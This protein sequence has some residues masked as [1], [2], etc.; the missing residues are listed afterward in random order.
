MELSKEHKL[1]LL[2]ARF[3][4]DE[5]TSE[6]VKET[7]ENDLIDTEFFFQI[8]IEQKVSMIVFHRLQAI[9]AIFEGEEYIK[10]KRKCLAQLRNNLLNTKELLR[11]SVLAKDYKL[12]IIPY[13]GA[14][15][16]NEV[17]GGLNL[18]A[19]GDIDFWYSFE[20][21]STLKKLMEDEGYKLIIDYNKIQ[22][23]FFTKINC[24]Y[25]FYKKF[26][27]QRVLIE[28]HHSL[29][30]HF[31]EKKP[32]REDLQ[33]YTKEQILLNNKIKVFSPEL[34]LV[35]L[36]LHHGINENWAFFKHY[37]DLAAFINRYFDEIN[38]KEVLEVCGKYEIKKTFL[39]GV[40]ITQ[41]LLKIDLPT[42]LKN[43]ASQQKI[44]KLAKFSLT[45]SWS[46]FNNEKKRPFFKIY[47]LWKTRDTFA[48]K[49][50]LI[51]NI[52][53]YSFFRLCFFLS[54]KLT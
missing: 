42:T 33:E 26:N 35:S 38:W 46:Y 4:F 25:H 6:R 13:K 2:L 23:F 37:I 24:E 47:F 1:L 19:S 11:I 52:I 43:T 45:H 28:P 18:R 22:E 30:K 10:F 34:T 41:Q 17:Y 8:A 36:V 20:N 51:W 39:V 48:Q 32:T 3:P 27:S 40:N 15:F 50:N 31:I 9:S 49:V 44:E 14:V 29:I 53:R 7:L 16:T 21:T 54:M 12:D 5:K